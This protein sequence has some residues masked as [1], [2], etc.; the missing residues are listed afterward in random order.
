MTKRNVSI[1]VDVLSL[2]FDSEQWGEDADQF[3]PSR[4]FI[5]C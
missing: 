3:N 5:F 4:Y 2:H 1:A